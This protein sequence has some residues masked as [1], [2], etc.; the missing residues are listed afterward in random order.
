MPRGAMVVNRFRVPPPFAGDA[1]I[2]VGK[3]AQ[4]VAAQKLVLDD[5][6]AERLTRAHLDAVNLANLDAHHVSRM[7]V[8]LPAGLPVVKIP[9]LASDV[10]DVKLLSDLAAMLMASRG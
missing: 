7:E 4:A 5:D 6:A 10:H 2:P 8:Q 3:A 1:P 9:E